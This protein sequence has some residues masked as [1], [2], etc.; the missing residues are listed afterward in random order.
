V[1][2]SDY[3]ALQTVNGSVKISIPDA[4]G[5]IPPRLI[6]T[7]IAADAFAA[8]DDICPHAGCLV[9]TYQATLGGLPCP[10]HGSLFRPTGE[11]LRG[12]ATRP[13]RSFQ[14]FYEPGS[15]VVE[16]E[17]PGYTSV[18]SSPHADSF[19]LSPNP[20]TDAVNIH[21]FLSQ[22]EVLRFRILT[23]TGQYLVEWQQP[24]S[25]GQLHIRYPLTGIAAGM[26]WLEIHG[27]TTGT[28]RI[29]FTVLR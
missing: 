19:S 5:T 3:P 27:A 22:A 10:C 1:S 11:V 7:R 9:N 18:P 25:A 15:T 23:L 16:I 14:T 4:T 26:Y 2:L 13:L 21:G 20:A 28:H 6:V 12:P 8:V 17:I 24:V 29:P